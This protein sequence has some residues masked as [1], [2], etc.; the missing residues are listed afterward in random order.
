MHRDVKPA[1]VLISDDG[2]VK[3]GDFGVALLA[4]GSTD[5][6]TA[7]VVGTPRYMAPE[8]AQ[9]KPSTPA[10]DVYSVGIV[11]YEMLSGDPPFTGKTV[12][13]L[14]L[15][16]VGVEPGSLGPGTPTRPSAM[17]A[18]AAPSAANEASGTMTL[19]RISR[20]I[21]RMDLAPV[22]CAASTKFSVA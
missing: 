6:G 2:R 11:L 22:A 13:E 14:A 16:H 8:Q 18:T 9:G 19:G 21:T 15:S 17:I 10:T 20:V 12:A 1:N 7:T 3:V 5:A 4:E